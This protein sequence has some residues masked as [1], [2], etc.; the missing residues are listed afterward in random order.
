MPEKRKVALS[1]LISLV[2][3]CVMMLIAMLLRDTKSPLVELGLS[4][5]SITY[6]GMLGIFIQGV[7]FERFSDRAAL[8]GVLASIVSVL[9][10]SAAFNV[11]WPW[12][13][14]I[15]FTVSFLVGLALNRAMGGGKAATPGT[16]PR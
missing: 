6:G 14:P 11:F 15:G 1:R 5:A 3:T 4:I 2:W 13:V 8:G 9:A 7:L 10:I 16:G 12:Y